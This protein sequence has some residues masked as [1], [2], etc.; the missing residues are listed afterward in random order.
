MKLI[1][2]HLWNSLAEFNVSYLMKITRETNRMT[3]KKY[4]KKQSLGP[5]FYRVLKIRFELALGVTSW[6]CDT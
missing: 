5:T 1:K 4:W 2:I 3:L 6:T